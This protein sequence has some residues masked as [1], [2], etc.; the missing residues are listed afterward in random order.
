[1]AGITLSQGVPEWFVDQFKDTLYSVTQQTESLFGVGVT[2]EPMSAEDKAFDMLDTLDLEE[3]TS[4]NP[5]TPITDPTTSRR[6]VTTTPYHKGILKDKDEDLQMLIDPT[7][8]YVRG[9]AAAVRRQ[10]D[11]IILAAFD[12]TVQAGR[13]YGDRTIAWGSPQLGDTA[14]SIDSSGN[15]AGRT[16]AFDTT[17]GNNSASQVGMSVEKAELIKEYFRVNEVDDSEPIYCAISPR[18]GTQLF[19]EVQYAS[20][21]YNTSK[22]LAVGRVIPNWHGIN[23]IVSNKI[24]KGSANDLS[25]TDDVYNC[26]AWV[27]SGMILGVADELSVEMSI[28]DDL[29][30]A[31]QIYVHMNMGAMRFDESKVLRIE[32]Q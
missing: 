18:Q 29:S 24:L 22:P 17:E 28:R 10:K 30:Y 23:W 6:W 27:P 2:V 20:S 16:I 7:S 21:D 3:K 15:A 4:S 12:A 26:W 19:G 8:S 13:R 32:C 25:S 1:V 14:Y 5:D 11:D 31:Q 9:F